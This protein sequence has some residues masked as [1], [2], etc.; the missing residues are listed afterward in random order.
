[1]STRK[2]DY[3]IERIT[4]E[5][6]DKYFWPRK[7]GTSLSCMQRYDDTAHQ[8]AGIDY[9]LKGI[10]FDTKVKYYRCL[11]QVLDCPGFEVSFKNKANDI[12]D[13]WLVASNNETDFYEIVCLS[14]M[15]NDYTQLSASSQITGVDI[16]FVKKNEL[17]D[18]INSYTPIETLKEDA[19]QLRH[20]YDNGEMEIDFVDSLLL[21]EFRT[22][23]MYHKIPD[24][25]YYTHRKF[26]LKY[27]HK[28]DEQPI[29]VVVYRDGL[30]SLKSTK[31]FEATRNYV[32][33]IITKGK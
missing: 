25:I 23:D 5:F 12:Q 32:K 4:N 18:Y 1:M 14:C 21:P 33:N 22:P 17:I 2:F 24:A 16:L 3:I 28:L 31:N 13:G 29:N 11:N 20:R 19:R 30:L 27:S 7:L 26:H 15:T 6:E 10:K 8:F 9:T